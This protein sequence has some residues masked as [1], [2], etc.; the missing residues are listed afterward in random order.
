MLVQI[1]LANAVL[2][3]AGRSTEQ[4]TMGVG[5]HGSIAYGAGATAATTARLL[6]L[7]GEQSELLKAPA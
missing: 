7:R 2:P 3:N 6:Y 5:S 1:M 4:R